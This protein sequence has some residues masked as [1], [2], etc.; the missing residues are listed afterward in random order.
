MWSA[1]PHLPK[2]RDASAQLHD[3]PDRL[4]PAH[5]FDVP[6]AATWKCRW[7]DAFAEAERVLRPVLDSDGVRA[8]TVYVGNPVAHNLDLATYIG[9]TGRDARRAAGMQG[10]LLARHRRPV[11]A[12]RGQ[13]PAVRRDVERARFPTSTAPITSMVLGRESCRR[14]RVRCCRRPT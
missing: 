6:V 4:A 11:A 9:C 12:E 13:R 3:D 10:V 8:L 2:G 7:D 14:P 5:W 1:R